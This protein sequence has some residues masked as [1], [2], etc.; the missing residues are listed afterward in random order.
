MGSPIK[1]SPGDK[2][3]RLTVVAELPPRIYPSGSIKRIIQ[4]V[5]DCGNKK[6]IQFSSLRS[7]YT[8][9]CGCLGK[10]KRL[11]AGTKH[12][13]T[14]TKL[15]DIWRSMIDRT[16]NPNN[17]AFHRYGGRGIRV[18]KE[19]EQFENFY[20]DMFDL[21]KDGLEIDRINNDGP[22]APSNCRWVTHQENMKNTSKIIWYKNR[23]A[24]YWA[25][26]WGVHPATA[27]KRIHKLKNK[28]EK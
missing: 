10:E 27:R 16:T 18:C 13:M 7:K 14:G 9:S 28:E 6:S 20:A 8:V 5:C 25:K 3:G 2:Y 15:H 11:K 24:S 19:W 21:H 12:G 17:H 1:I 26:I 4:C 23:R 22:Y